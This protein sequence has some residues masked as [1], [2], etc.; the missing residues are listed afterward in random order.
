MRGK[1][2]ENAENVKDHAIG[3]WGIR[4]LGIGGLGIG[5]FIGGKSWSSDSR[6]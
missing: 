5:G 6:L 4:R 1:Y 2:K 3:N